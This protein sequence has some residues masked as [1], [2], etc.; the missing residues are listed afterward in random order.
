M[1]NT[2]IAKRYAKA[3]FE[4]AIEQNALEEIKKDI[5]LLLQVIVQNKDFRMLLKSPI[6]KPG[7]KVRIIKEIFTGKVSDISLRYFEIITSKRREAYMEGITEEFI[8]L[9]KEYKNIVTTNF[10]T[11]VPMDASIKR[12]VIKLMEGQTGGTIDF[13]EEINKDL[14]GGFVLSYDNKKYDASI[15]KEI[16]NLKKDFEINLYERKL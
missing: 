15:A 11:V 3:L 16:S 2:L 13:I 10:Q 12:Q 1:K 14:I 7:R 6:V 8:I 4:F 9:Y 5:E